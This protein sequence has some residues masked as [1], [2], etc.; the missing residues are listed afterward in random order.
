MATFSLSK[1]TEKVRFIL[2]KKNLPALTAEVVGVLDVSGSTKQLYQR[3]VI[4]EAVQRI[5]PVAMNFDDNGSI[6][7]Y[8]FNDGQDYKQTKEDLSG[9]NYENYVSNLILRRS[10]ELPLWG[11][12]DYSP[13]LRQVLADLGFIKVPAAAAGGGFLSRLFHSE[14]TSTSGPIGASSTSGL[15]AIIYVVTD[16]EN[17]DKDETSDLLRAAA[18]ANTEAYFNFIGVGEED[19]LYLHKIADEFP[20][21]GFAQIRD[22]AR[23]AGSD[24]IYQYLIP[25][26]LTE[27]LRKFVK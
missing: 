18:A 6:P 13:V 11:A 14:Q 4:Q 8:V 2:E 24:D 21:T 26:E 22:L 16:G 23:T 9:E 12:T 15:P 5:V 10:G 7:V 1:D 25:D 20:N 19:F 3:G 17:D 27:W